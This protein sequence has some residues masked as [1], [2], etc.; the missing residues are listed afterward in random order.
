M[1]TKTTTRFDLSINITKTDSLRCDMRVDTVY[2]ESIAIDLVKRVSAT[3]SKAKTI[4]VGINESA[5]SNSYSIDSANDYKIND[6]V[7]GQMLDLPY[8]F[9]VAEKS[10]TLRQV[11]KNYTGRYDDDKLMYRN[12]NFAYTPRKYTYTDSN[13]TAHVVNYAYASDIA[14]SLAKSLGL[15]LDYNAIDFI[16]AQTVHHVDKADKSDAQKWQGT[17]QSILSTLFG[18]LGSKLPN[19]MINVYISDGTLHVQQRGRE[20]GQTVDL[21]TLPK[22]QQITKN[23]KQIRT[24][25]GGVGSTMPQHLEAEAGQ[26]EPFTGVI[27]FNDAKSVYKNGYLVQE[28]HGKTTTYYQYDTVDDSSDKYLVKQLT[29][30]LDSYLASK[31]SSGLSE[32]YE[33]RVSETTYKYTKT[34]TELYQSYEQSRTGGAYTRTIT[35]AGTFSAADILKMNEGEISRQIENTIEN[36][37]RYTDW[38]DADTSITRTVPLANGWYGISRYS[39]EDSGEGKNTEKL[40]G[41]SL[42]QGAP[43]QKASQYMIDKASDALRDKQALYDDMYVLIRLLFNGYVFF[44]NSFPIAIVNNRLGL[45][46]AENL[47][48]DINNLNLCIEETLSLSVVCYNHAIQ[49]NDIIKYNGIQYHLKSNNITNNEGRITQEL[50][51]VRW[52]HE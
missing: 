3:A 27:S 18:W 32:M 40:E 17:Y 49:L 12:L 48:D 50:V 35:T 38:T 4:K 9:K 29:L 6:V 41:S 52:Y 47:T 42:T 20:N 51:L 24:Q 45:G 15:S 30:E 1:M 2:S 21:D 36:V 28:N 44:D 34:A 14:K 46:T 25:W 22:F 5:L 7:T 26:K 43:G 11:I 37:E 10:E 8:T 13:N 33:G 19:K 39:V 16:P 31:I 23:Y